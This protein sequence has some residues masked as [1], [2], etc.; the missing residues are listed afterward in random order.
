[1]SDYDHKNDVTTGHLEVGLTD[2][3]RN[4]VINYGQ[5]ETD[6]EGRGFM[7]F[8]ANQARTL[9]HILLKHASSIDKRPHIANEQV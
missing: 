4:I 1:M 8:S 7:I 5:I 2:D 6:A 3:E 9:A